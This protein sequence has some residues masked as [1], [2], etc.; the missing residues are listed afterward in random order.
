MK[1]RLVL[2]VLIGISSFLSFGLVVHASAH[3]RT[4]PLQQSSTA[5]PASTP[6]RGSRVVQVRRGTPPNGLAG[7]SF[8][9]GGLYGTFICITNGEVYTVILPANDQTSDFKTPSVCPTEAATLENSVALSPQNDV[10]TPELLGLYV[11]LPLEAYL[12]PGIW[13]LS[14]A[15]VTAFVEIPVPT[16]PF[17]IQGE[18]GY[19][20]GGFQPFE[21]IIG[22][23][24]DAAD[25]S[26]PEFVGTFE[27]Q[28]DENGYALFDYTG[29]H[30]LLFIGEFGSAITVAAGSLTFFPEPEGL[31]QALY[32]SFWGSGSITSESVPEAETGITAA[33][34]CSNAGAVAFSRNLYETDPWM[35]GDDV[36]AVQI[37]LVEMGYDPGPIDGYYGPVTA[38]AVIAYQQRNGLEVDGVVGPITWGSLFGENPVRNG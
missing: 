18:G 33:S 8:S 16:A 19:V 37:C 38:S 13:Q 7:L 24:Y 1:T 28:A 15:E 35:Y 22:V 5:T 11:M 2:L 6:I 30:S 23:A 36:F 34:S 32:D 10:W 25:P 31:A 21:R 20:L 3:H 9:A 29:S 12:Q 26:N 4:E 14:S 27:I 17:S